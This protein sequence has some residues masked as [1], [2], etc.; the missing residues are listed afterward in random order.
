VLARGAARELADVASLLQLLEG[1][2]VVAANDPD[3]ALASPALGAQPA[4]R[5]SAFRL[6]LL[7]V[8][9]PAALLVQTVAFGVF[10]SLGFLNCPARLAFSFSF[11]S[12]MCAA[13]AVQVV[14]V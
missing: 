13:L 4:G 5:L 1:D 10:R 8:L 12:R 2:D 6:R 11:K 14:T 9:R 7:G 3:E